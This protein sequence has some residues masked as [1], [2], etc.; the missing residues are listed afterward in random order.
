MLERR[1]FRKAT[2][3]YLGLA[4]E[5]AAPLLR[6]AARAWCPGPT[7][8]PHSWR[9]GLIIGHTHIGDVLYRTCSLEAL[10][11]GLPNCDWYYLAGEDTAALLHLN[12]WLR[13]ALPF[14]SKRRNL[15]L[16]PGAVARLRELRFDV[17]LCTNAEKY[18]LDLRVALRARIPNRVGYIHRGL[19]ALV[20]HPVACPLPNSRAAYFR[21]FVSQITGL[22]PTWPLKP[23]MY[24]SLEDERDADQAWAEL[25][26]REDRPALACFMTTRQQSRVWPVDCYRQALALLRRSQPVQIVLAGAAGDRPLLERF[27]ASCDFPCHLLAGRLGLG[28]LCVFLR[29]CQAVLAPDSGSRHIANAAGTPVVFIRDLVCSAVEAGWYCESEIDLTPPGLEFIPPAKQE[30]YLRQVTPEQMARTL[31]QIISRGRS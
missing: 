31:A 28:A 3:F 12:P 25:G 22:P 16:I 19:S 20:T 23:Q 27:A 15:R 7:G 21:D 14:G 9:R 24:P 11:R 4:S 6:R 17:A 8:P 10:K 30:P 13:A 5:L 26:L 2:N 1:H 29:R 18:W